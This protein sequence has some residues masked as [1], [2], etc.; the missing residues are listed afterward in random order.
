MSTAASLSE[1]HP[2]YTMFAPDW[3]LMR[4]TYRGERQVKAKGPIY[5]P[6]TSGHIE[7]GIANDK[8]PGWR[9]YQAYKLRAR[10]P[11]YIRQ[12][13]QIA[14]GMLHHQPA[15]IELPDDMKDIKSSRGETMEQLLMRINKEQI[16]MGRVGLMMDLPRNA[17][18]GA[19]RPYL[20][21][22][23]AERIIN[24][25]NGT[26]EDNV[27]QSLNLVVLDESEQERVN[28][29]SWE[30]SEKYRV[31]TLGPPDT[32]EGAGRYRFGV[33]NDDAGFSVGGLKTASYRGRGLDYIPFWFINA[34]DHVVEPEDPPLLDLANLCMTIY[35]GEA[36]YRQNLF[37]QGQDTFVTIGANLDDTENVRTGAG[38]RL[39]LPSGASA[40]YVGVTSD[41]LEEQRT[42]LENDR[43]IAG[44]MGAQS[45]DTTSR[46][47]ESGKSLNIRLAARTADLNQIAISGGMGLQ[48][49]LR[50]VAEWMGLNPEEVNVRPNMEFGDAPITGQ[51]MV[52][53]AAAANQ[54]WP[55][56]TKTMHDMSRQKGLTKLTFEEETKFLDEDHEKAM[57][58]AQENAK[59]Q[60]AAAAVR[61][62]GGG[63]GDRNQS[64]ARKGGSGG[65][66][67]GRNT[68]E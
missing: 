48:A 20:A 49:A 68:S 32:N 2:D 3:V 66:N 1:K 62:V 50:G 47:R 23:N 43:A 60:A 51:M 8:A 54:G 29:F 39:D 9:A 45:I 41:G 12:A 6:Y 56:S 5:L 18:V 24:W 38:A 22:Y 61:D 57:K 33:F 67:G 26:V 36:D 14:L 65:D 42:S 31:L 53:I 11:N 63:N 55:I 16:L 34:V 37:M 21:L 27:P 46:E 64:Q 44:A 35:R 4:D 30:A 17:P 25:D 13:V 59:I 58:R 52:D 19:D 10:F 15:E 7:D 28:T 40:E